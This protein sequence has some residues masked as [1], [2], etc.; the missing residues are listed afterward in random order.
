MHSLDSTSCKLLNVSHRCFKFE[1]KW[2]S[3]SR[4]NHVQKAFHANA[5]RS[6][7][8]LCYYFLNA[9]HFLRTCRCFHLLFFVPRFSHSSRSHLLFI[10]ISHLIWKDFSYELGW[11]ARMGRHHLCLLLLLLPSARSSHE[12]TT[13]GFRLECLFTI[14]HDLHTFFSSSCF[15]EVNIPEKWEW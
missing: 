1:Y 11:V 7:R 6:I 12:T 8:R 9:Q 5:L 15:G 14:I 13:D 4:G 2:M 10:V 3:P